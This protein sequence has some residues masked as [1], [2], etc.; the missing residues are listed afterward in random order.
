MFKGAMDFFAANKPPFIVEITLSEDKV[1]FFNDFAEKF[2]YTIYFV[3]EQGLVKLDRLY[4]FDKWP[5]FLFSQYNSPHNYI[6]FNDLEEF[7]EMACS[8]NSFARS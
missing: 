6:P 7:A 1:V 3:D 5:N 2:D 4:N 8:A